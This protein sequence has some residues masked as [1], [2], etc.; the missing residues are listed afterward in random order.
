MSASVSAARRGRLVVALAAGAALF[1]A[2]RSWRS[3]G[4]DFLYYYCAGVTAASGA[5]PYDPAPY[6]A[7]LSS[8]Y[9][10]PNPNASRDAGSAYPPTAMPLFRALAAFS[11]PAA[12]ALWNALLLLVTAA[13]VVQLSAAPEDALLLAVWP[14]FALCWTYH[15]LT[16]ILFGAALAA[17]RLMEE[18]REASGGAALGLL[19]LQPQWLA[20]LG[21][22][23]AARGRTRA[24]AAAAATAAVLLIAGWRAGWLAQWLASAA[25]HAST[26]IGYD[27]QSLFVALDKPLLA[28]GIFFPRIWMIRALR[29]AL[30]A[31]LAAWAWI[32]A[33]RGDGP[34]PFLGLV[35]LAQPYSHASDALWAFPFFL[36]IRD[37]AAARFGWKGRT[38]T[39]AALAAVALCWLFFQYG[40]GESGRIAVENREGYLAAALALAW[41]ALRSRTPARGGARA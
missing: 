39:A 25:T 38:P 17:L 33:R 41:L 1:V 40:P 31:A 14:G 13:L 34:G 7:C 24:L 10:R 15:K 2:A 32:R 4:E 20:A 6:Q 37:R 3:R 36:Y 9:G 23:A 35:L 29:Y 30:S 16:L 5:S 11:Y 21:L 28:L 26:L 8:L 19:A 18:G 22:Y 12:Y 27:N